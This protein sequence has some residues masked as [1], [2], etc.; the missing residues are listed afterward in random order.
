MQRK[1]NSVA[2]Q[3]KVEHKKATP[4]P[5]TEGQSKLTARSPKTNLF[6]AAILGLVYVTLFKQTPQQSLLYAGG[7][8]LFFCTVDYCFLYYRLNKETK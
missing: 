4:K 2:K 5:P 3:V 6:Y 7:A 8:F 1:V